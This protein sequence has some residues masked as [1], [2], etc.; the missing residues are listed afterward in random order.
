MNQAFGVTPHMIAS[1]PLP[2]SMGS[3][4][5]TA[6][7]SKPVRYLLATIAVMV[8]TVMAFAL[9]WQLATANLSL[10]FLTVV[11]FVAARW[12]LGPSLWSAVVSFLVFNFLFISPYYTLFV[13]SKDD[14]AMLIFFLIMATLAGNLAARM[15]MAVEGTESALRHTSNLYSFSRKLS[16]ARASTNILD[17]LIEH[18]SDTFNFDAAIYSPDEDGRLHM[19]L[20][21]GTPPGRQ[22]DVQAERAWRRADLDAGQSPW[23][24]VVLG[25]AEHKVALLALRVAKF[26]KEKEEL[27]RTWCDQAMVALERA[28]LSEDLEKAH[29]TAETERLRA[30]LLS[31]VSH[32][33]RTPLASIIGSAS[34]IIDLGDRLRPD[35]RCELL[36]TVL[37]EAERL[38]RYIQNLL[39]MTRLGHGGLKLHRDWVDINDILSSA[40]SRLRRDLGKVHVQI[41]V[42]PD[43][44]LIYVHGVLLEQALV[45]LLDNAARYS[46]DSGIIVIRAYRHDN[47]IVIDVTDQGPGIPEGERDR[48]FDMFYS[49]DKGDHGEAGTGLGLAICRGLIGAHGGQV[50]ALAGNDGQGACMRITLPYIEHTKAV[51]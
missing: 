17:A 12:G 20:S 16:A 38:N 41:N 11:I 8:G 45:N 30:A 5:S 31:S 32:D 9:R 18:V 28:R 1:N 15:R 10:V 24:F 36:Q 3:I 42:S 34:S 51:A 44:T 49:I 48:I 4:W 39:D 2:R 29:I 27:V 13:E 43:A 6:Q 35:Q 37:D 25:G 22:A 26:D 46:P 21:R 23:Y 40:L 50:V 33:L 47:Q 7:P 19:K 14:F